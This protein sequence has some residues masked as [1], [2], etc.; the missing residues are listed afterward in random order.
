MAFPS[1]TCPTHSPWG[2]I[3]AAEQLLPGIW[4]ASTASHGGF[5]LSDEREASMPDALRLGDG[6]Y[7]EDVDWARVMVAFG[8]EFRSS[9]LLEPEAQLAQARATLR[10]WLPDL[11]TAHTGEP[12][13]PRDNHVIR[14]RAAFQAAIGKHVVTSAWGDWA[15]WVPTGKVG[16]SASIVERVD[17][18]GFATYV[19]NSA[20]TA[21]LDRS[22]Y[23]ASDAFVL[24]D[25]PHE[26]VDRETGTT[27]ECAPSA[28]IG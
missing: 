22:V 25:H 15:D 20:V 9:R 16:V 1:T 10:C 28:T 17:H 8:D 23:R 21:F 14:R 7:E 4:H 12:V 24:E 18:K 6:A 2:V 26:L 19:P 11:W 13:A 27:K 3:R 5:L